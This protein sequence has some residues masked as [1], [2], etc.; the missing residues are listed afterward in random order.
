MSWAT[1]PVFILLFGFIVLIHEGG[2]FFAARWCG[3]TVH[4]F[5][6]G[7]G[8]VLAQRRKNG[9]LYS[10][11]AIPFG[12]FVKVAGMD[13][14]LEGKP[15]PKR[16][17]EKLFSDLPCWQKILIVLSGPLN[18]LLCALLTFI[19]IAAVLGLPAQLQTDRAVIGFVEPNSPA[20]EA[21]LATGDEII[22]LNG[23]VISRWDQLSTA[24]QGLAHQKL[25]LVIKR[26]DQILV[27]E[28]TPVFVRTLR[29]ARIGIYPVY[30]VKKLPWPEAVRY[31][32]TTTG[33]QLVAIPVSVF[34][35]ITGRVNPQFIGVIGMVGAIDQALKS[36]LYLLFTIAASLNLFLGVF[37]LLPVPLPLLDGGWIVIYLLEGLRRK[38]FRP[39]QKAVAQVIGVVLIMAFYLT[40][41]FSDLTSMLRRLWPKG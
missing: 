21:G 23:K 26:Q 7:L 19:F 27:R 18:N 38:E 17:G 33:R 25:E 39:E 36:G 8:P 40:V 31:G 37:N 11:R 29:V 12:G 5:A 24:I 34:Q 1:L 4:E 41:I 32:V 16:P 14:V 15:A 9:V 6:V 20:Y 28:L 35:M 2:H 13:L 3:V 30:A 10:I 22:A